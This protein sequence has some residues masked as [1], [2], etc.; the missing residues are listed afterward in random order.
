VSVYVDQMRTPYGRMIMCHLVA[1][2]A[3]ELHAMAARIGVARR[4]F[5]QKPGTLPH[6][7]ICLSKRALA[8]GAGAQK[9]SR[10]DLVGRIRRARMDAP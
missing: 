1:D 4:W 9:I 6:Y 10:E 3:A 5:Q 2:T 8:L 7:D